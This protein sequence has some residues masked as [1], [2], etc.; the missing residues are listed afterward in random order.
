MSFLNLPILW[1]GAIAVSVPIIIHLLNKRQFERISW[2]AMRFLK[3]S[4]EQNQRRIK[5]EDMLLLL[6]RC[7]LL[8][9]LGMALA[10]PTLGCANANRLLGSQDVTAVMVLDNSYSMSGTDGVKSRFEQAKM[11]AL[12]VLDTMPSG[13]SVAVLLASDIASPIIPEPTHDLVKVRRAIN[14]AR[15]SSRGSNLLPGVK[16]A[17][18]TLR[19]RASLR[20]E[21][22]LFTDGQLAAWKQIGEIQRMLEAEK[23]DVGAN[24]VF[25]GGHEEENVAVARLRMASG[26]VAVDRELRFEAELRNYGTKPA[27]NV[28]VTLRVDDLEP[29]D[30]QTISTIPVGGSKTVSLKAKLRE[31]GYHTVTAAIP[32]DHLRADDS[33]TIA[34]RSSRQVKALLVD[35]SLGGK[36]RDSETFYLRQALTP[37]PPSMAE[38]YFLK[39]S[40]LSPSELDTAKFDGFDLVILANVPDFSQHTLDAFA[41]YLHRGSGLIV[42]PGDNMNPAFY[43]QT[44]LRKYHFLPA[45]FG[46]IHGDA[47]SKEKFYTLQSSKFDHPIASIW[48]D[49]S[50]GSPALVEFWKAY[51]L[52]PDEVSNSK[53]GISNGKS[54]I[55]EDKYAAEAGP[56]RVILSFGKGRGDDSLDGKPAVIERAWGLGRVIQFASALT[57]KWTDLPKSDHAGIFLPLVDRLVA[58]IVQRQDESLNIRVGEPFIFHPSDELIGKDVLFFK[59]EQKEEATDSRQVELPRTGGAAGLPTLTYD[60]TDLAGEYVAKM[61]EGP[62]VKFA[63]QTDGD[64]DESSLDEISKAQTDELG[65]SC[66]ISRWS[67]GDTLGMKIQQS[68]TGTELWSQLAWLV[69]AI[70][71]TEMILAKWFSRTK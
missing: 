26:L 39:L 20:K 69:L 47:M 41:D 13:S 11:A 51:D 17:L 32:P 21:I 28:R 35:G 22:H 58:G 7:L 60:Q 55:A 9:L 40:T 66:A 27:E 59:P 34:V 18:D 29:T 71:A 3:I 10:R 49:P 8:L 57:E 6:L 14:E 68:R 12:Q 67:P 33:R 5:I 2:A 31:E 23:K 30:E 16:L 53:S 36:P 45:T 63:V 54:E 70:A 46:A 43:N 64:N 52:T 65:K 15:L 56:P 4:V 37:V 25:V 42:I 61:P 38:Q 50:A 24:I 19:G 62:P 44:L 48:S 1:L